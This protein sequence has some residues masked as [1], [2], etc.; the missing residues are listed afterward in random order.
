MITLAA[1]RNC[2]TALGTFLEFVKQR[3]LPLVEDVEIDSQGAQHHHGSQLLAA[4]MDRWPSFS[5]FGS[6]K[7]SRFHR[8]FKVWNSSHLRSLNDQC[9][10]HT[11][12]TTHPSQSPSFG[13]VRPHFAGNVHL[14]TLR[15]KDLAPPLVPLLPC[16]SIV[17]PASEA[18]VS[19]KTGTRD[20]SVFLDQRW[21]QWVNKLLAALKAGNPEEK[22]G[23]SVSQQQKS[24]RLQP[25]LWTQRHDN[26]PNA[27]QWSQHRSGAR[28]QNSARSAKTRSVECVQQCH[29]TRQKQSSGSRLPLSPAPTLRKAGNTRATCRGI[30]DKATASPAARKRVTGKY[31]LDV[32]GGS[33]FLRKTTKH[34]GLHGHEVWSTRIRQDVSAGKCVA[35]MISHTSCSP[36]VTSASATNLLHPARTPWILEH[37]CDSWLWDGTASHGLGPGGFLFFW[38]TLQK[39][40]VVSGWK[41]GQQRSAPCCSQVC[42]DRRA[43][44]CFRSKTW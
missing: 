8:C 2:Q 29:K 31:M 11:C 43:L 5:R 10:N 24:S 17:I 23:I 9:L 30:V 41:R 12:N 39:A 35:G 36:K 19:T 28:F 21:L 6:R 40:N 4:V 16:W 34:M 42:W 14:L 20:G 38:I 37:P 33:G 13:S 18:G 7:L 3:A 32:F 15:K 1:R 44:Q 25:T 27:P 26:V 22:P